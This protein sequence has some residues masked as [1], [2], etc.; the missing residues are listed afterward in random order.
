[1]PDSNHIDMTGHGG[2][3][4]SMGPGSGVTFQIEESEDQTTWKDV[5]PAGW[6]APREVVEVMVPE[7]EG[8]CYRMRLTS[9]DSE[10]RLSTLRVRLTPWP[11][12]GGRP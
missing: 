11:G 1:M 4:F 9:L 10:G 2:L 5:G 12:R 6:L 8:A 3:Q 7:D